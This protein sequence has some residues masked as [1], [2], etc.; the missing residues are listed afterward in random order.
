VSDSFRTAG[1]PRSGSLQT[2]SLRPA[3]PE[4]D[5]VEYLSGSPFIDEIVTKP[6]KLDADGMLEI[7]S[8]PGLGLELDE[9]A[10][11]KYAPGEQL[12]K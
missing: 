9:K 1:T 11:A 7:P 4:T 6:W 12:F 3:F 10:V 2:C 8:K 5:L